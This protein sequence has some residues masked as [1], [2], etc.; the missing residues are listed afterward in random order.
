MPGVSPGCRRFTLFPRLR[1]T[2][3]LL[4]MPKE[5][6]ADRGIRAE[7]GISLYG[8]SFPA[9]APSDA[10]N[11]A[12][13]C[14]IFCLG[15]VCVSEPRSG[16]DC[17]SGM[18]RAGPKLQVVPTLSVPRIRAILHRFRPDDFAPDPLPHGALRLLHLQCLPQSRPPCTHTLLPVTVWC[19]CFELPTCCS[20][21]L[22]TLAH[23]T[24]WDICRQ[25]AAPCTWF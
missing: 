9:N 16:C 14:L 20:Q 4:M 1:A 7:V 22:S 5:V 17:H 24:A 12:A 18:L 8:F 11:R 21:H 25:I 19:P 10:C 23:G 3:D 13:G 15:I 6:L 2:A